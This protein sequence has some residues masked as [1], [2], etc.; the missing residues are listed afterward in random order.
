MQSNVT[1]APEISLVGSD[2]AL[3]ATAPMVRA[4]FLPNALM[5]WTSASRTRLYYLYA[6]SEVR[7]LLPDGTSGT[8]TQIAV[9]PN[10]QAG[11]SVS[12][13][14][15]KIAVAIFSYSPPPAQGPPVGAYAGM[16]LYVEDVQGGGHHAEIFSSTTLAEFP[17][18]WVGGRLVLAVGE[19]TCCQALTLNPYAATSYHIVDPATGNRLV[20]L[21]D[22]GTPVG[23]VTTAGM[24]CNT[25]PGDF[26][27]WDGSPIPAPAAMTTP[28][29]YL[30]ALSPDGTRIAVGG[31][32]MEI[33]GPRGNF[34]RLAE[35]GYVFGWLDADRFV[36]Q[37]YVGSY[38]MVFDLSRGSAAQIS[39]LSYAFL[40][41]FPPAI[42]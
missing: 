35:S 29:P 41:T 12:P 17:I 8:A 5:P 38:L 9:S 16:R 25:G 21:C 23:P 36:Y 13:D 32:P 11:F 28:F 42:S 39:N 22:Q 6:G 34:Y 40:G 33:E 26:S 15:T 1:G 37:N 18:G 10:Q 24:I 7:Y 4:P 20:T 30:N 2:G 14:D 31:Q 3:I 27:R 19:P